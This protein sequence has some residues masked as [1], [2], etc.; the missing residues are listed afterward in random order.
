M[1]EFTKLSR[2]GYSAKLNGYHMSA[3][4]IGKWT[5]SVMLDRFDRDSSGNPT[6]AWAPN[7]YVSSVYERILLDGVPLSWDLGQQS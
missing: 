6:V 4:W 1:L 2:G 3:C 7:G 5:V